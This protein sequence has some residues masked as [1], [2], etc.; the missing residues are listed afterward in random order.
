MCSGKEC[1]TQSGCDC[2]ACSNCFDCVNG[3][4]ETNCGCK[5]SGKAC[6]IQSGCDCG[7]CGGGEQCENSQCVPVTTPTWTD[8]S[9]GLEWQNPSAENKMNWSEAKQYCVNLS[10]GDH[11][12]WHLPTI[13]ELRSL[14]RGCPTTES[15]GSCNIEQGD[16]LDLSCLDDSCKGCSYKNG[17]G[18]GGMYWPA[19]IQGD[20][21]FHWSSSAVMDSGYYSAWGVGFSNG[22]VSCSV[23]MFRPFRCVR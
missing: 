20:C 23:D 2:G 8:P 13:G 12:D 18:E 19:E 16:C 5:C 17:P 3:E 6:G 10:L 9:S 15:G 7:V 14:I 1:G 22:G 4:C 11:S 21:C